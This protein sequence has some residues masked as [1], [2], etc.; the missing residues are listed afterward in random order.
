[1]TVWS[2]TKIEF[3][4]Q[5]DS[6][7]KNSPKPNIKHSPRRTASQR[8]FH[9]SAIAQA[10]GPSGPHGT[11]KKPSARMCGFGSQKPRPFRLTV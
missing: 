3:G 1:M 11:L 6:F 4:E 8:R 9:S 10:S 5:L 7:T 2:F